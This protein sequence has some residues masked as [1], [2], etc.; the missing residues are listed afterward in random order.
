METKKSDRANLEKKRSMFFQ[1]GLL[2]ALCL[3]FVA[4]EWQV[5]VRISDVEWDTPFPADVI[6]LEIPVTRPD[7][8]PPAPPPP[9]LELVIV[10]N[11]IYV[12]DVPDIVIDVERGFNLLSADIFGQTSLIEEVETTIF[13]PF[14]LEEQALFD[15]KPAEEAFRSYIAQH[16]KYPQIAIENGIFGKVFVQFVV[17]QK[18]NVVDV[19]VARGIDPSLD[20]EALRLIK[21]TSGKWSPGKQ[22][23]KPVKVRYTFPIAFKLK[24]Q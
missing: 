17:D 8:P 11:T 24:M 12:G 7:L 14:L 16:L 10:D 22:Q 5:A 18:G 23:G 15:G 13:D 3:T 21:S 2:L 1:T 4:F 9:S 19:Q 20:N 6:T